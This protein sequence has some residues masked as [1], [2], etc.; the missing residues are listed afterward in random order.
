MAWRKRS[1][2]PA[3]L[4]VVA[5]KVSMRVYLHDIDSQNGP[6]SCWSYVSHGLTAMDQSEIV[7]TLRRDPGE[8]SDAFPH[9]P[10]HLLATIYR[11][12]AGGQRVGP[13]DV[14][15]FGDRSFLGRHLLYVEAQ[16]LEQVS[17]PPSCLAALLV[18]A[19]ELRAVRAFGTTRVLARLGQASRHYPFP[20]WSDRRRPGLEFAGAFEGSVLSK[21]LCAA[22]PDVRASVESN[23]IV[24]RARRGAQ[25]TW[26][27]RLADLPD[28][29][30]LAL[31]TALDPAANGCLVWVPG[32]S[33]PEAI[34]PPGS[35][36]SRLCGCFVVFLP[37]QSENGG[38]VLRGMGITPGLPAFLG[39]APMLV[40]A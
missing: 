10:L 38:R 14:T 1:V 32:Q 40:D 7:F 39:V 33:G 5:G 18:T 28:E 29:S 24:V 12:A 21:V 4:E 2:W 36:G 11:L 16:P 31:L 8:S 23:Q 27:D 6:I 37:E 26:Q 30:P 22:Q 3:D 34:G 9:D 17:L 25:P 13:G 35:D 15:E 19:D 20:P